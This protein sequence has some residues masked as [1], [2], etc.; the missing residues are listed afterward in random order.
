[1]RKFGT[2]PILYD[3]VTDHDIYEYLRITIEVPRG[4]T[5]RA[6]V[7][8][9]GREVGEIVVH[10]KEYVPFRYTPKSKRKLPSTTTVGL[11]AAKIIT[12]LL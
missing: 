7:T 1:M 6:I 9:R 12:N 8:L 11:A 4:Q 5:S 3:I 10:G 2:L